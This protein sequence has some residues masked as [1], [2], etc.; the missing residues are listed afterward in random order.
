MDLHPTI[1]FHWGT[2][3]RS[4]SARTAAILRRAPGPTRASGP[5]APLRLLSVG[6]RG[7]FSPFFAQAHRSLASY[8]SLFPNL[9]LFELMLQ[10]AEFC[11]HLIFSCEL[12]WTFQAAALCALY[13][14]LGYRCEFSHCLPCACFPHRQTSRGPSP[15]R[16]PSFLLTH[17]TFPFRPHR[18]DCILTVSVSSDDLLYRSDLRHRR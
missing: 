12:C 3:P 8:Q 7:T 2:C 13:L 17:H 10:Y 18:S 14:S 5:D 4:W 9:M 15:T 6:Q 1:P 16:P 11:V